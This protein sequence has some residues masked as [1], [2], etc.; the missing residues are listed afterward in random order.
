[1]SNSSTLTEDLCS[2]MKE[3]DTVTLFHGGKSIDNY[4]HGTL[5]NPKG[6]REYGPGLYLSTEYSIAAKSTKGG[7]KIYKVTVEKGNDIYKIKLDLEDIKYFIQKYVIG[8]KRK[9][10]L[11]RLEGYIKDNKVS[12]GTF[13]NMIINSKA[14]QSNSI[15]YLKNFLVSKGIDYAI[16]RFDSHTLLIVMNSNKIQK[17][18]VVDHKKLNTLTMPF[19]WK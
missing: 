9:D 7:S 4:F 12:A 5:P 8:S 10:F 16:E 13:L 19:D 3:S 11:Y 6:N 14:I 17:V 2:I 18:E 15:R 1:M